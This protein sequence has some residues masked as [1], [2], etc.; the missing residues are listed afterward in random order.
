MI[1]KEIQ[2][3]KKRELGEIIS[4]SFEFIKQEYKPLFRLIFTYVIPFLVLYAIVQ[5]NVQQKIV[6]TIDLTNQESLIKNIGPFYLN[7]F[8][9]SLFG[10]FVH[11][12][13]IGVLYSYIEIYIK[14]GKGKFDL[15]EIKLNL[16]ANGQLA[17]GSSIIFYVIV[18]FGLFLFIVPG[19]YFSI[20]FSL[21]VMSVL[22]EK[23]GLGNA[24]ARSWYLVRKQWWQTFFL[25]FLGIIITWIA[26]FALSIPS[27]L[28]YPD[29]SSV[30]AM[31]TAAV[32]LSQL[33]WVLMGITS[34]GSSLFWIVPFT[35]LA[36]QYFN[37]DERTKPVNQHQE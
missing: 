21:V 35:F 15:S 28:I 31:E 25:I 5:I 16:F 36:F 27:L 8:L 12:L 20:T 33:H 1:E 34:V 37:L 14:K 24:F 9:F 6:G 13:L 3:R 29:T 4:D 19:I 10:V 2:F 26:G 11:A 18:I 22:F 30:G 23:K 32:E 7:I 17:I